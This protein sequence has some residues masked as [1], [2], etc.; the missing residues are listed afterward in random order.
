[1][2][3][4]YVISIIGT[5]LVSWNITVTSFSV[6][7]GNL[8]DF[9]PLVDI[10]V[11]VD[12]KTIRYLAIED[13]QTFPKNAEN[14][15]PSFYVNVFINDIKFT[16]KVWNDTK[17]VIEPDWNAT[18]NVPDDQE[19]VTITIQLLSDKT[20]DILYDLSGDPARYDVTLLYSIKTGRWTGDDS[21]GDVSGYGRLCGCDDGTIYENDRDCE[22]WFDITQNDYD[23]DSIPYWIEVNTLGTDPAID[24]TL[25]DP[26]N[27]SIPSYWEYRW[28]YQPKTWEDFKNI[29]P[30]NDSIN[31]IEEFLT[32]QWR[33]DPFRIDVFVEMD[34]MGDGPN[35]EKT[36]FPKNS[37]ELETTAFAKQN[38]V[39]HL[40]MGLM[41]GHDIIPFDN[42]ID[43]Q[44]RRT[45]VQD[46][47]LHGDANN[48]R[49]GVF[50]YGLVVYDASIAGFTFQSN[51]FQIASSKL[52][53]RSTKPFLERDIV[54]ASCYMHELGHTFDFWPI[55]G[56]NRLCY[57]P[58]QPGWWVVHSYRSCMNYGWTYLIVD[59]SDGSRRS[60]DLND[61]NRIDYSSFD[62]G[63]GE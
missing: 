15:T 9:D 38:I 36:Y 55:P 59:Y 31:N 23:G 32:S 14:V 61:W 27:D 63:P 46:Y 47:F 39:F 54:Y 41:G 56:H 34:I 44:E 30:D 16:S 10:S 33:S 58:W 5:L 51:A 12:M 48:W 18:L 1:M 29:D 35:G 49:Q 21:L 17:Y 8:T 52:E 19:N 43:S 4:L 2:N 40:D 62:N 13:I 50:H 26:D 24:D 53:N 3:K 22:L 45:I 11:T 25:L 57:Y 7:T 42:D 37:A 6:T 20:G 60:P 28:G